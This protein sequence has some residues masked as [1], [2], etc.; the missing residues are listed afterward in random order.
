VFLLTAACESLALQG[1]TFTAYDLGGH[2]RGI[3]YYSAVHGNQMLLL[4]L[5]YYYYY[6][7]LPRDALQCKA[8]Y[9]DRMSSVCLS[10]CNVGEL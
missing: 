7:L 9:C 6:L 5:K 8:R 1:V 4:L 2:E 3:I 10:V